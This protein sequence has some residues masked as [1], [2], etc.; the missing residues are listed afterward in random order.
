MVRDQTGLD[1][2]DQGLQA[3]DS[4]WA[5]AFGGTERQPD[6]MQRKGQTFTRPQ[7]VHPRT[8]IIEIIF[9]VDFKPLHARRR[10]EDRT[11]VREPQ[12]DAG[13]RRNG[14]NHL[15][16]NYLPGVVEPPASLAQRPAGTFTH[17]FL[18]PSLAPA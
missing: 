6:G 2:V 11:M 17:S 16:G 3:P 5:N 13:C 12:A 18:S 15:K 1:Q 8:G 7:Q 10:H 4:D 9:G 14:G